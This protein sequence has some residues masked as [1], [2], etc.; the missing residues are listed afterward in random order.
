[1]YEVNF[2]GGTSYVCSYFYV[3]LHQND[4][5]ITLSVTCYQ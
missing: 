3:V 2:N 5:Y 4:C 1:M